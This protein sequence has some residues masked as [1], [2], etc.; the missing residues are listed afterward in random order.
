MTE[1]K[2]KKK[3]TY[4]ST[5][6]ENSLN[7]FMYISVQSKEREKYGQ[8]CLTVFK[9]KGLELFILIFKKVLMIPVSNQIT[10]YIYI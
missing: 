9:P 2:N 6:F 3:D 7:S 4:L 8:T 5:N 10:L 1:K